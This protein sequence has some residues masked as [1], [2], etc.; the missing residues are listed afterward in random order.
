VDDTLRMN[1]H[2]VLPPLL[3]PFAPV[4]TWGMYGS[5]GSRDIRICNAISAAWSVPRPYPGLTSLKYVDVPGDV[6]V[7]GSGGG[8][9]HTTCTPRRGWSLPPPNVVDPSLSATVPPSGCVIGTANA[10]DYLSKFSHDCFRRRASVSRM[11]ILSRV[12][13]GIV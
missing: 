4:G 1:V 5:L 13:Y 8:L 6:L 9:E 12:K 11:G 2:Y 10:V 7:S 3:N